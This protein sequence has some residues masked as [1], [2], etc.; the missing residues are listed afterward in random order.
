MRCKD[1]DGQV[2]DGPLGEKRDAEH[3]PAVVMAG[4]GETQAVREASP[5][6]RGWETASRQG[7]AG[8]GANARAFEP[9]MGAIWAG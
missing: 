2:L 5:T 3:D 6:R 4:E 8:C 1:L 9:Q 7:R